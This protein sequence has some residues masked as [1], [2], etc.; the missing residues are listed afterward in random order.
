MVSQ[1]FILDSVHVLPVVEVG[2][3]YAAVIPYCFMPKKDSSVVYFGDNN[4]WQGEGPSG[5]R[6]AVRELQLRSKN[7]D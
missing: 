7:N 5:T 1:R 2:A 4:Q 6:I 3:N